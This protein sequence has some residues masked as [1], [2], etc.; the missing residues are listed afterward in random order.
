M[1]S[2]VSVARSIISEIWKSCSNVSFTNDSPFVATAFNTAPVTA[3]SY[4]RTKSFSTV[5]RNRMC[6]CIPLK[7]S[8]VSSEM[9]DCA[10]HDKTSY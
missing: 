7:M 4:N 8:D 10:S 6:D 9:L 2:L 1:I 5:I 3:L